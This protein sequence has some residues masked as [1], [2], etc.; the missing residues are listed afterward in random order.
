MRLLNRNTQ[1][2]TVKEFINRGKILDGDGKFTGEYEDEYSTREIKATVMDGNNQVVKELFGE[3]EE[4]AII[5]YANEV[6]SPAHRFE[7]ERFVE[8][9]EYRI[10][11]PKQHLNHFVYGLVE[12]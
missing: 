2:V 11:K 10:H 8:V 6:L 4:F 7:I 5:M 3:N 12:I 9:R 1:K